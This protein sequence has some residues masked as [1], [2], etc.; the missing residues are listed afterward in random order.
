MLTA[1]S[2]PASWPPCCLA[3]HTPTGYSRSIFSAS[4][5]QDLERQDGAKK[6]EEQYFNVG[7]PSPQSIRI[8]GK[9]QRQIYDPHHTRK[10]E[11]LGVRKPVGK[12]SE[13]FSGL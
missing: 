9:G 7:T 11:D 13:P 12:R 8:P 3:S 1:P 4:L 2:E 6:E 10:D 5:T